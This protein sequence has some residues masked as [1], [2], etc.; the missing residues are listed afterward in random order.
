MSADR[1]Q[2]DA[3]TLPWAIFAADR[4]GHIIDANDALRH[5]LGRRRDDLV[6]QPLVEVFEGLGPRWLDAP[7]PVELRLEVGGRVQ[8]IHLDGRLDEGR[9]EGW[10]QQVGDRELSDPY[11]TLVENAP[12]SLV[13]IQDGI[14]VYANRRQEEM[15]PALGR[16]ATTVVMEAMHP[17]DRKLVV[18]RIKARE[19]GQA[20]PSHY[21][22]RQVKH[23]ETLWQ[24]VWSHRIT[25][26]GR[27]AVQAIIIDATERVRAERELAELDEKYHHAQ[28]LEAIG[29]LAGGV[30]HDFN[31][32]LTVMMTSAELAAADPGTPAG[33]RGEIAQIVAAAE[34]GAELTQQLLAFSRRQP[35][36]TCRQNVND[37]VGA[38][39]TML[40][41]LVGEG[42]EVTAALLP[43][44]L[45]I[46]VGKG[47]LEQV[48]VNLVVNARDA[49]PE[50]GRIVLRTRIVG[51]DG[52]D[53]TEKTPLAEISV[54][55]TGTGMDPETLSKV[56]EPFFTTKDQGEGTGLGLSMVLG[57]TE[58][59]G[60][61]L[62]IES[63]PERGTTVRLLFPARAAPELPVELARPGHRA[64]GRV[65]VVEDE[66]LVRDLTRRIL[67]SAGFEVRAVA[68]AAE[69][70]AQI[71]RDP[72]F[73]ALL[74]DVA[75]PNMSGIE[76]ARTLRLR[77][78]D[79]PT[80]FMTGYAD[81]RVLRPDD[82]IDQTSLLRKPFSAADVISAVET[83]IERHAEAAAS[84]RPCD[85][86]DPEAAGRL[87]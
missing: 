6:G 2:L 8:T 1:F 55:D 32:L 44:P 28:K 10:V 76:L 48:L 59:A 16:P 21:R 72:A 49:M 86:T 13:I 84:S 38:M 26:R 35:S 43:G 85:E 7:H 9:V 87:P 34:R 71:E 5:L 17:D 36:D 15:F 70:L 78:C 14:V 82:P 51:R 31:N 69:A 18:E 27:S 19:A 37:V 29:R 53:G 22:F 56:C 20:V 40:Q 65:L 80:V 11:L 68:S 41:R 47:Q 23:G 50:G 77:R 81:E 73:D 79:I 45:W 25:F 67:A 75:M 64:T 12:F 3:A 63:A 33:V 83:S 57:V 60:G 52:S 74:T 58:N 46:D 54:E 42:V 24:E 30:A 61:F 66:P 62:E 4:D 39:K